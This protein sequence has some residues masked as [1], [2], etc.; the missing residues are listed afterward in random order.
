MLETVEFFEHERIVEGGTER[1]TWCVQRG[2][3]WIPVRQFPGAQTTSLDRGPGTVWHSR[4]LLQLP[5]DSAAMR[6]QVI[7]ERDAPR[8]VLGYLRR[9][10]RGVVRRTLRIEFTVGARGELVRKSLSG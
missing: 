5:R 7:P 6:I 9:E 4:T 1:V 10:T 3:D 8:D 2:S